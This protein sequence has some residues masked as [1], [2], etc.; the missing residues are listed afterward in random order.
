[1]AKERASRTGRITEVYP[2]YYYGNTRNVIDGNTV[3]SSAQPQW[4][5]IEEPSRQPVPAKRRKKKQDRA[6]LHAKAFNLPS[7]IVVGICMIAAAVSLINYV[8]ARSELDDHIRNIKSLTSQL[9]TEQEQ[10]DANL[11]SIEASIDYTEI[12]EYAI[13][14]LGMSYP[15]KDQVIWFN[16]TESEYVSQYEAIPQE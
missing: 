14:E 5:P 10:N 4:S 8:G 9:Q 12:F 7:L 1:M 13:E 15:G 6:L 16:S 11:L 3:R 2:R